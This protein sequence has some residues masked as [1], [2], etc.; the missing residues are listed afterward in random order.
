[1]EYT[2]TLIRSHEQFYSL[3]TGL[4]TGHSVE[5]TFEH[6]LNRFSIAHLAT[7]RLLVN[8]RQLR[9]HRAQIRNRPI[10]TRSC[11]KRLKRVVAM[12]TFERVP[13]VPSRHM[14][15]QK[16]KEKKSTSRNVNHRSG[17]LNSIRNNHASCN[18]ASC[19]GYM[20]ML[21]SQRLVQ[22]H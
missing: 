15:E 5:H 22:T 3:H 12:T 19:K 7:N 9:A 14:F 2:H 17:L 13:I 1:M 4:I 8:T 6:A 16:E 21:H 18:H 10:D 11:C 20:V